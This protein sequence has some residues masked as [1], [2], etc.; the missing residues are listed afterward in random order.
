MKIL[1]LTLITITTLFLAAYAQ[2]EPQAEINDA[3]FEEGQLRFNVQT[4]DPDDLIDYYEYRV[5]ELVEHG[6]VIIRASAISTGNVF[7]TIAIG[8]EPGQYELRLF[9]DYDRDGE[10]I[11]RVIATHG[12]EID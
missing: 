11:S 2:R 9:A 7:A 8:T 10:R 5:V 6:E 3:L 12:F 4:A 1:K